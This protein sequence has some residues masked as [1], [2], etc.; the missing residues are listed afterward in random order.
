VIQNQSFIP[1]IDLL[2]AG[3]CPKTDSRIRELKPF[4]DEDELLRVG[5]RLQHSDLSYSEKH[6]RILPN[7]APKN[8]AQQPSIHRNV[9]A[10]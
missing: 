3:K 10:V 4:L 2:K 5:G 7:K 9:G 1:E 8:F 6:P